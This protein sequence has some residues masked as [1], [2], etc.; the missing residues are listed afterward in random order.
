MITFLWDTLWE[1]LLSCFPIPVKR[2]MAYLASNF[3]KKIITTCV[4]KSQ[5]KFIIYWGNF[6]SKKVVLEVTKTGTWVHRVRGVQAPA[7]VRGQ[8]PRGAPRVYFHQKH[9]KNAGFMF[10]WKASVNKS[11]FGRDKQKKHTLA[12]YENFY[13]HC[14]AIHIYMHGWRNI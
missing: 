2:Y 7:G 5:C 11:T 6:Q 1:M 13:Q 3:A 14:L 9:N 4:V 8:H 12:R 10:C